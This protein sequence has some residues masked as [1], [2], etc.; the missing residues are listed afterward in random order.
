MVNGTL[1]PN[2]RAQTLGDVLA[3]LA[4]AERGTLETAAKGVA[5][6]KAAF[7]DGIRR[8]Y[9][10][11]VLIVLIGFFITALLPEIPLRKGEGLPAFGGGD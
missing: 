9:Q 11:G 5:V 8:L 6:F 4:A 2:A 3:G 1:S 10:I 7:T